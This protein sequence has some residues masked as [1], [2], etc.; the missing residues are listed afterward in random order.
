MARARFDRASWQ[1]AAGADPDFAHRL[2][3]RVGAHLHTM[4]PERA[5]IVCTANWRPAFSEFLRRS[6]LRVDVFSYAEVPPDMG[7][8]PA[9]AIV[10]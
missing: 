2:L 6:G 10:R 4:P 1:D 5:A 8:V 9:G 3:D 7:L